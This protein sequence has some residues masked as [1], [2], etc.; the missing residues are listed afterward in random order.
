MKYILA[1]FLM[2]QTSYPL[3]PL[4]VSVNLPNGLGIIPPNTLTSFNL[5]VRGV[6]SISVWVNGNALGA[7]RAPY[8]VTFTSL[9]GIN[10]IVCEIC[11]VQARISTNTLAV[12]SVDRTYPS[13]LYR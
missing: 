13:K 11:D 2:L 4:E 8:T 9:Q 6:D 3:A 7:L 5:T 1:L 12:S 10:S